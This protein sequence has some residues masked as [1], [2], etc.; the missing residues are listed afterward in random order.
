[1]ISHEKKFIFIHIPK[2][3]GTS[4]VGSHK[5]KTKLGEYAFKKPKED[6]SINNLPFHPDDNST[7]YVGAKY[8]C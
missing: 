4:I 5:V 6:Y 7:I 3:A 2:V 1:M 8:F